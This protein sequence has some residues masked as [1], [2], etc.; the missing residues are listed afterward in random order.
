M[1][2]IYFQKI[3]IY[4]VYYYS[5][6]CSDFGGS[7]FRVV[8]VKLE[9]GKE[10]VTKS[11]TSTMDNSMKTVDGKVLFDH[12]ASFIASFVK[13]VSFALRT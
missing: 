2:H 11:L 10:P 3:L 4:E 7:T 1:K 8:Y 9:P 6:Y 13:N 5:V 12:L